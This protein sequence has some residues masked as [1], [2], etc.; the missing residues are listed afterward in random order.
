[1]NAASNV[2]QSTSPRRTAIWK[3][4]AQLM[5]DIMSEVLQTRQERVAQAIAEAGGDDVLLARHLRQADAAINE[6]CECTDHPTDHSPEPLRHKPLSEEARQQGQEALRRLSGRDQSADTCQ[7]PE[8]W[9]AD[10]VANA[11]E[12]VS[13]WPAWKTGSA[14][15]VEAD[16]PETFYGK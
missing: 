8:N 3:A 1:M 13:K 15:A 14:D 2:V 9:V 10:E 5:A 16:A 11:E 4:K 7:R 6:M 12:E